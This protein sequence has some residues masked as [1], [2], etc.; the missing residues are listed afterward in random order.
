MNFRDRIA[1][2]NEHFGHPICVGIDPQPTESGT[3]LHTETVRTSPETFLT[4][5][6]RT[7]VDGAYQKAGVL[8]FQSA[9]FEK[10][11]AAGFK[12]LESGLQYA[13]SKKF[14]CIL[15]A[16]RGDISSTMTAYGEAAFDA[17]G[18]DA[19]TVT[20]YMGWDVF[21]PLVP[22]LKKDCGVYTVWLTSNA[23]AKDVQS[24]AVG[25]SGQ[26]LT[27]HIAK[28][29]SS[30]AKKA[31]VLS[32]IG[33]VAGAT[34]TAELKSEIAVF[35]EPVSLLLPGVGAQGGTI[36]ADL[37][38]ILRSNPTSLIP[39]SRGL[40]SAAERSKKVKTW[41]HFGSDFAATLAGY[42]AQS[43]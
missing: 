37:K 27:G 43:K 12:A 14:F 16:K 36:D 41:D 1:E 22:W 17:L 32:S 26:T 24:V 31:G 21:A 28:L 33:W 25:T 15:D 8:K 40:T 13:K 38:E 5:Y 23:A 2:I 11:G 7:I 3:F 34:R 42:V 18:A 4:N 6:V 9:F 10:Y 20:P 35:G 30:E 29:I 39:I 19:L